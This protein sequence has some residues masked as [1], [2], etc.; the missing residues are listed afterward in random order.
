MSD[1]NTASH[2]DPVS[3]Y[4]ILAFQKVAGLIPTSVPIILKTLIDRGQSDVRTEI[5]NAEMALSD[6]LEIVVLAG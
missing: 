6:V 2:H 1:V 4:A 5:C 3:R